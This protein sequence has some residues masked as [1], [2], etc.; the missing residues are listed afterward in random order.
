MRGVKGYKK[1][2]IYFEDFYNLVAKYTINDT[3]QEDANI[4]CLKYVKN[5][6]KKI[7]IKYDK[8]RLIYDSTTERTF[9]TGLKLFE[10]LKTNNNLFEPNSE[11]FD[12]FSTDKILNIEDMIE[13]M[14]VLK[15]DKKLI[16]N[17]VKDCEE[18]SDLWLFN[19]DQLSNRI[20]GI[21]FKDANMIDRNLLLYSSKFISS[22]YQYWIN[23]N[24]YNLI[25]KF[26]KEYIKILSGHDDNIY[27]ILKTFDIEIDNEVYYKDYI[28]FLSCL[29]IERNENIVTLYYE[30]FFIEPHLS[31]IKQI[32]Y[33]QYQEKINQEKEKIR[34]NFE[35]LIRDKR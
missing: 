33:K 30:N 15:F 9:T 34:V 29:V 22:H 13:L 21:A 26:D 24:I 19:F 35:K 10:S 20:L 23:N 16:E 12:N 27:A 28:N 7:K 14:K 3:Y 5:L 4:S 18:N 25:D 32:S 2:S 1:D 17:I 6:A 8:V 31:E 11:D